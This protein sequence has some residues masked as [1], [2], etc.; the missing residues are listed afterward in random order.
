MPLDEEG[1]GLLPVVQVALQALEQFDCGKAH[2]NR[3]LKYRSS[4]DA[5]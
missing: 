5:G 1:F 3:P 4:P 2:L